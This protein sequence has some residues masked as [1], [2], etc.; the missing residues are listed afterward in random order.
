M[1]KQHE[2]AQ[3]AQDEICKYPTKTNWNPNITKLM[4]EHICVFM[5]YF[6]SVSSCA[7][8][9]LIHIQATEEITYIMLKEV[10]FYNNVKS[11]FGTK[12]KN[13]G[14]S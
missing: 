6:I 7:C 4:R 13:E 9:G 11:P 5:L 12:E 3:A 1:C 2:H 14:I 10:F 8:V